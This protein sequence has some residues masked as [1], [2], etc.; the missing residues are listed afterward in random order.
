MITRPMVTSRSNKRKSLAVRVVSQGDQK[1]ND[2]LIAVRGLPLALWSRFCFTWAK[3]SLH[4][5]WVIS[6]KNSSF[7]QRSLCFRSKTS[8]P[9]Q[10]CNIISGSLL[11][12]FSWPMEIQRLSKS[13]CV[14]DIRI[15]RFWFLKANAEVPQAVDPPYSCLC[16][17]GSEN[18]W[19]H[20]PVYI[21]DSISQSGGEQGCGDIL[22]MM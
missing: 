18:G 5:F 11:V 2:W 1:K 12:F 13:W 22:F 6:I 14:W 19:A 10:F 9:L 21:D 15:W 8:S 3:V 17:K 4:D 16:K 7:Y 20:P